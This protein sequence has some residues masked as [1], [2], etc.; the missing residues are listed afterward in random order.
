[1]TMSVDLLRRQQQLNADQKDACVRTG[2]V[3]CGSSPYQNTR[4]QGQALAV[5]VAQLRERAAA[6]EARLAVLQRERDAE[7]AALAEALEDLDGEG[8]KV[9]ARRSKKAYGKADMHS[10]LFFFVFLFVAKHFCLQLCFC[11][12]T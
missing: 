5:E 11:V 8:A 2:R 7:R 6:S 4:S 3:T 12:V 1:M 9:Q 10:Q